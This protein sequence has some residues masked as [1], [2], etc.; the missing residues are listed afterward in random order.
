MTA[1]ISGN[2]VLLSRLSL[3]LIWVVPAKPE[4]LALT[5]VVCLDAS[6]Y[7]TFS[8][9][10]WLARASEKMADFTGPSGKGL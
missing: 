7:I 5:R 1:L 2:E 4:T 8:V 9:G 6:K 3:R 10:I